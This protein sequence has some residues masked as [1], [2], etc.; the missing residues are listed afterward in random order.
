MNEGRVLYTFNTRTGIS[1]YKHNLPDRSV[2][3]FIT[4]NNLYY[5]KS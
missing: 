4:M 5:R 3:S 1:L 2:F